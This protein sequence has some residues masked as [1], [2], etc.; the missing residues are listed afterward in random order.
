MLHKK[1]FTECLKTVVLNQQAQ[2][3][4]GLLVV[5]NQQHQILLK[6]TTAVLSKK[7]RCFIYTVYFDSFKLSDRRR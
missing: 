1:C 3:L 2:S 7:V 5:C 4:N 6:C